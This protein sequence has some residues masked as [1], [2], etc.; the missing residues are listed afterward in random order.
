LVLLSVLIYFNTDF[1]IALLK[2][3]FLFLI[4]GGVLFLLFKI[5]SKKTPPSIN[6]DPIIYRHNTN[7]TATWEPRSYRSFT[8]IV[9]SDKP[10]A[11]SLALLQE[12]DWKNFEGLCFNY[13]ELLGYKAKMSSQGADEG[14]DI[15]LYNKAQPDKLFGMVQCKRWNKPVGVEPI[16]AFFGVQIDKKLPLAIFIS[17]SGFSKTA[18]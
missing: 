17:S 6:T 9:N 11:W 5:I 10:T 3:L 15:Y 8:N 14:V 12:I 16:R 13:F 7:I 1:F 2:F 18:L 4:L